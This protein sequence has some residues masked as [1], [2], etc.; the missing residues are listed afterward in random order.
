M[1]HWHANTVQGLAYGAIG[2]ANGVNGTNL[3]DQFLQT[4]E[5]VDKI[6]NTG[7]LR[8]SRWL[9]YLRVPLVQLTLPTESLALPMVLLM[10]WFYHRFAIST[11]GTNE[12]TN[13]T[14]CQ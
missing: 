13:D 5:S 11:N 12:D 10:P 2:L 9:P 1:T 3:V 8:Y 14:G 4:T 7:K 6:T